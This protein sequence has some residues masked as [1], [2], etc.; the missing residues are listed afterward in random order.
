MGRLLSVLLVG[1]TGC[2]QLAGID[3]TSGGTVLPPER[4]SFTM[5]R[6]SIGATVERAPLDLTNFTATYLIEDTEAP[7][8]LTRVVAEKL[9]PGTWSAEIAEGTPPVLYS[10]PDFP[11]PIF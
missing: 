1:G 10:L 6:M 7:D 2:A 4:V 5:E 8:G 11:Q 9:E 3:E